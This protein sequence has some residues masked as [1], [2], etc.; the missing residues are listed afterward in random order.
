MRTI[1]VT[2]GKGGVGKTAIAVSL[3]L[4]AAERNQRTVLVDADFGLANADVHLG[5]RPA[6]TLRHLVSGECSLDQAL[7]PH[8]SGLRLLAGASGISDLSSFGLAELASLGFTF[9]ALAADY[10][11]VI[12][13]T[14][15]GIGSGVMSLL[16]AVDDVVVVATPDPSSILDSYA[17]LKLLGNLGATPT[18]HLITNM[19][20]DPR[21]GHTVFAR[22]DTIVK[23]FL[24]FELHDLGLISH[25]DGI[26]R[27]TLQRVPFVSTDSKARLEVTQILDRLLDLESAPVAKPSFLQ[28]LRAMIPSRKAA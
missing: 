6:F 3:A 28:R 24:K 5:I 13:D 19:A 17:L 21:E 26:R 11:L 18:A 7:T 20:V 1:A 2:G 27:A 4:L 23:D 15:A 8:S 12:F 10:D 22:L 16:G 14:A 9:E 25:S